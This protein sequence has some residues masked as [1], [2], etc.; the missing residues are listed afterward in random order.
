MDIRRKGLAGLCLLLAVSTAAAGGFETEVSVALTHARMAAGGDSLAVTRVHL[1]HAINCLVGADGAAFDA[2]A[3]NPCAGK[4]A[5]A[6]MDG[7]KT[8]TLVLQGVLADANQAL[9]A[10][11]LE[12]AQQEAVTV[13]QELAR[14]LTPATGR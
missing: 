2:K 6:L 5:G 13:A 14:L 1:H 9:A 4:G 7:S 8:Q 3:G 10:S 11:N 12:Q